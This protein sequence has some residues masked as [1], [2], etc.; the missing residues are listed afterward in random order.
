MYCHNP[1]PGLQLCRVLKGE[2]LRRRNRRSFGQSR[3]EQIF[4]RRLSFNTN[5]LRSRLFRRT[6]LF[7]KER[8]SRSILGTPAKME[9]LHFPRSDPG[10]CNHRAQT[11]PLAQSLSVPPLAPTTHRRARS[12][13]RNGTSVL[14]LRLNRAQISLRILN[15]PAPIRQR[16]HLRP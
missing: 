15:P 16:R 3:S 5:L 14:N 10:A 7:L 11:Q 8:A 6:L 2:S 1:Q 13:R 9:S 4:R 12:P